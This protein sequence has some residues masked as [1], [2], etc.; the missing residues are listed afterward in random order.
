MERS[1]T[2]PDE[3]IASLLDETRTDIAVLDARITGAMEGE[4]RVL[5]EGKFWGVAI[6]ASS[7]M[8]SSL[9]PIAAKKASAGS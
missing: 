7:A 4:E 1:K 8:A 6:S 2:T 5:L 9:T 3:F